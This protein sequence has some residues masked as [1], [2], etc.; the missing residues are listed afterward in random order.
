MEM[1]WTGL[2]SEDNLIKK[3]GVNNVSEVKVSAKLA[4]SLL[5]KIS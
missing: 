4:N 3:C 2:Q 5:I 1:N